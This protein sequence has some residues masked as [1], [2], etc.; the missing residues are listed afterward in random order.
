MLFVAFGWFQ[1]HY[2]NSED[3]K[4]EAVF[5]EDKV[6]V[7]NSIDYH[8]KTDFCNIERRLDTSLSTEEFRKNMQGKSR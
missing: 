1:T 2:V 8:V 4:L 5:E 7:V 3:A 6:E